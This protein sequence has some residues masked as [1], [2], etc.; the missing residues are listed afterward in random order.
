MKYFN[1]AVSNGNGPTSF[2]QAT[3][4]CSGDHV[5]GYCPAAWSSSMQYTL[6]EGND[7]IAVQPFDALQNGGQVQ[8][9][10]AKI[11]RTPPPAPALTNGQAV[12][13]GQTLTITDP[14]PPGKGADASSGPASV[15][16][17]VD[18]GS[19]TTQP[20]TGQCTWTVPSN[21]SEGSHTISVTA[22]DGAGNTGAATSATFIVDNTEPAVSLSGPAWD[23]PT[24]PGNGSG[25]LALQV[26]ATDPPA[27]GSSGPTAGVVSIATSV[28]GQAYPGGPTAQQSCGAGSCSLSAAGA[29]NTADLHAGDN[30]VEVDVTDAAG[31]VGT[32]EWA[33]ELPGEDPLVQDQAAH[34][35]STQQDVPL[36]VAQAALAAQDQTAPL[37][38]Q[39]ESD[40]GSVFAGAWYD[41][42][43]NVLNLAV[44]APNPPTLASVQQAQADLSAANV[45]L[46]M[47]NFVPVASNWDQLVAAQ[48]SLDNQ[49]DAQEMAG[50]VSTS[51]DPQTN[52][53]VQI[54]TPPQMVQMFG[55]RAGHRSRAKAQDKVRVS[56]GPRRGRIVRIRQRVRHVKSLAYR[57]LACRGFGS[58][59][60]VTFEGPPPYLGCDQPV[61]GGVAMVSPPN[62]NAR[63]MCTPGFLGYAA[64]FRV[65]LTAGHCIAGSGGCVGAEWGSL[66][67]RGRPFRFGYAYP[68]TKGANCYVD[69]PRGD[70]G[71]IGL[72]AGAR[73]GRH[74]YIYVGNSRQTQGNPAYWIHRLY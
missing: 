5:G 26:N 12:Q 29:I 18:G 19:A 15:S 69:D 43:T 54:S 67:L 42:T 58:F 25:T 17:S 20:C 66:N 11:D 33:I 7:A 36:N 34:D 14:D 41:P 68:S 52:S 74:S 30:V 57:A 50:Q 13:G 65:L 2:Q 49:L 28:N 63:E 10:T 22:T 8:S 51:I 16:I 37:L 24:A 21:L 40:L 46:T 35:Y 44:A 27:S 32:E 4:P 70:Y 56:R 38:P 55:S 71:T 62:T 48:D 3:H 64:G 60:G 72:E 31:N 1:L 61:R 9:W 53:V 47:V 45:P 6:P 59:F 39:L 73:V 23:S